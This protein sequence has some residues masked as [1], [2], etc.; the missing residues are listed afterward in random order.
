MRLT[1]AHSLTRSVTSWAPGTACSNLAR[2]RPRRALERCSW[3]RRPARLGADNLYTVARRIL[4]IVLAACASATADTATS[5]G[6]PAS[7]CTKHTMPFIV[8]VAQQPPEV[9]KGQPRRIPDPSPEN[10]KP[11]DWDDDDDG[12]WEP[13]EM[14][15]PDFEWEPGLIPNP[16]FKPPGLIEGVATEL[17]KA[18]PWTVIGVLIT[19]ALESVKISSNALTSQMRTC[20]PVVGALLGLV[21]PLC[22]C[23][24]SWPVAGSFIASGVPLPTVVA[25]LT[26]TQSTGLDSAAVT[27]GLLGPQAALLRLAGAVVLAVASGLAVSDRRDS[28]T[29]RRTGVATSEPQLAQQ[30]APTDDRRLVTVF[31]SAAAQNAADV[32]PNVLL[33]L[34][35]SSGALHVAPRL[36]S[37]YQ[38]MQISESEE[39]GDGAEEDGL[40]AL[41]LGSVLTRLLVLAASLPLQLNEFTTV[42]YAAAIQK[43][44]GGAGLAFAFLL[45]APATN[46]P[47][48][49]LLIRADADESDISSSSSSSSRRSVSPHHRL[50]RVG[51]CA[52][53]AVALTTT[54]LVLS[55]IVDTLEMDLFTEREADDRGGGKL[56]VLPEWYIR[57]SPLCVAVLAVAAVG[58]ALS[59]HTST[60]CCATDGGRETALSGKPKIS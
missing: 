29:T 3:T 21:T 38:A 8:D 17:E 6:A 55:Y 10:V 26:A 58:H 18:A 44:G 50:A 36:G 22:S 25:F 13:R 5:D 31:C 19:A 40:I 54:A 56:L 9:Y 35:L 60:S 43:A 41:W 42:A 30:V 23:G 37:L 51:S 28:S 14:D 1:H 20:G 7:C 47:S 32:F 24:T 12:L 15:N 59:E 52:R 39:G 46:L 45:L 2:M 11:A 16:D 49:L 4:A 48:M 34:F 53:V 27:S 57:A 33:G